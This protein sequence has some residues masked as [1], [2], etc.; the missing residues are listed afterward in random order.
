MNTHDK[1]ELPPLPDL[2]AYSS[3]V[4]DREVKVVSETMAEQ[5]M[6]DYARAAIA[7]ALGESK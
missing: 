2:P 7:K 4:F 3:E 1:Y 6:Q 5:L